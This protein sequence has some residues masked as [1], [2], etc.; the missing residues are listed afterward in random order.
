MT[1]RFA[2]RLARD[3]SQV[4]T[5]IFAYMLSNGVQAEDLRLVCRHALRRAESAARFGRN[6]ESGGLAMASLVLDTWHRDRR[7]LNNRAA[8]R[9]VRLLG[10]A[11]SVE[12]LIRVQRRKG[13][14]ATIARRMK[15]LRL[16]V[17][18]GRSLY[19]PMSDIAILSRH[20]PLVLQHA[21]RALSALLD[22]VIQNMGSSRSAPMIER[23]AEVPDLPR[24]H[25]A[26][27][28]QFSQVQGR[29]FLRTLNDW[30]ESRRRRRPAGGSPRRTVRA[31]VHLHAYIAAK[32]TAIV[33]VS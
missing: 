18:S 14:A 32:R 10:P 15:T 25:V 19:R 9:A 33:R 17:P 12:A 27:F 22:T 5:V 20:N 30:L 24:K 28:Q 7:Y 4:L 31:G 29:H 16:V 21:A 2:K 8:P 6:E 3:Y 23:T 13:D 26:A 11:P 1:G